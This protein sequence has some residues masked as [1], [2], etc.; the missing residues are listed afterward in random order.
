MCARNVDAAMEISDGQARQRTRWILLFCLLLLAIMAGP[1]LAGRLY[2]C[3]DLGAFHVPARRFYAQALEAGDAFDWLPGLYCGFYLTGEGQAGTYHPLHYLLYRFLPFTSAFDLEVLLNFP[4]LLC[5][6]YLF[7]K[8]W[9]KRR[10]AAL[11]G[12]AAFTFSGFCLL[13]LMHVNAMAVVVHLPWMLLAIDVAC[14]DRIRRRVVWALLGIV[15]LT[16]SQLLMGHPQFVWLSLLAEITY[17]VLVLRRRLMGFRPYVDLAVAKLIGLLIAAVQIL[18]TI[19][20]ASTATRGS[21]DPGFAYYGSIH[22]L[23]LL[24]LIGPYLFS[25]RVVGQNTHELGLYIGAVPL[26]LLVW[27]FTSR[28]ALG[29]RRRLIICTISLAAVAFVLALGQ[30]GYLYSLQT[31]L[32][33]VGRFRFPGRYVVLATL[34]IAIVVAVAYAQLIDEAR[35]P[36]S[37]VTRPLRPLWI[38]VA[39]GLAVALTAPLLWRRDFVSPLPYTLIGPSLMALAAWLIGRTLRGSA[40]AV[41]ALALLMLCDLGVYGL[42]YSVWGRTARLADLCAVSAAPPTTPDGR[43]VADF[44]DVDKPALRTGNSMLLTGWKRADGYAALEPARTL[45]LTTVRSM[46]VAG[47]RWVKR[48]ER[49]ENIPGLIPVDDEWLKVPNPLPRARLV[50]RAMVTDDP[51]GDMEQVPLDTTALVS[52]RI[53]LSGGVPGKVTLTAD[54]PG[55]IELVAK[56]ESR[57]LLVVSE[58]YHPGWQATIDGV[59]ASVVRVNGDFIGCVVD[60]GERHVRFEFR[61]RSLYVG[62]WLSSLG[63][64]IAVIYFTVRFAL[65]IPATGRDAT[66]SREEAATA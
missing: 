61:P 22:P 30:F 32:P 29:E 41:H 50:T 44:V 39:I 5:G 62:R 51:A 53:D 49:T 16:A 45:P 6:A 57:Q 31:V 43:I 33:V 38:T 56:A 8:R 27:L 12:A 10:D 35:R 60:P 65:T 59:P 37:H 25:T 9:V 20:A 64:A 34:A 15:V 28:R 2:T 47:V 63:M 19:D 42:S 7:L 66:R 58:S 24:Q 1:G 23:N 26:M 48:N 3:D 46:R 11:F 54:K 17:V 40:W 18:P 4:L 55:W 13:H 36:H 52:E 21:A 14:T